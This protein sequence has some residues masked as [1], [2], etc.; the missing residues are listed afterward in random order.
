MTDELLDADDALAEALGAVVADFRKECRRELDLFMAESR[1][2]VAELKGEIAVLEA[3]LRERAN[4]ELAAIPA[5]LALVKD[6]APGRDGKSVEIADVEQMVGDAVQ[7][8]VAELPPAPAGKDANMAV[9]REIIEAEVAQAVAA[10]PAPKD[11]VGLKGGFIDHE[12]ALV[13]TLS[14]GSVSLPGRVKGLDGRT[15]TAEDI[16]PIVLEEVKAAVA[17]LPEPEPGPPPDPDDIAEM[18]R[19]EID[20]RIADM[21]PPKDGIDGRDGVDGQDGKSV[22][23]IEIERMVDDAIKKLPVP[24]DGKD[25]RSIDQAEVEQMVGAA[26]AGAIDLL[27][28]AQNGANGCDGKD[29]RD[30]TDGKDAD[31]ALMKALVIQHVDERMA[32]IPRPQD[33]RDGKDADWEAIERRIDWSVKAAVSELPRPRD[34]VD[35]KDGADGK[36]VAPIEIEQMVAKAIEVLP[37]PRDGVDGKSLSADDVAPLIQGEIER[38]VKAI[39]APKDG[40]DGIDGKDGSGIEDAF[41]G[42]DGE[43]ILVFDKGRTK[44]LGAG[45]AKDINADAIAELIA[46]S[47]EDWHQGTWE[48]GRRY[49]AAK[50]T[51]YG[52]SIFLS[53]VETDEQPTKSDDWVLILKRGRDGKDAETPRLPRPSLSL[54]PKNEDV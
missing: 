19:R 21:P 18:V 35:G 36:S 47:F 40:R 27:P 6:G 48:P 29:G 39:P 38:Q 44:N 3:Q 16:R 25:G 7:K 45:F 8:A 13:L 54:P 49:K 52:G 5:A 17:A 37:K 26:V 14:D 32:A 34:G 12:G 20:R 9:V 22:D 2:T 15:P 43:L 33:G 46:K 4:A 51:T 10:I 24:K 11:G 31:P 23:P 28:P 50:L 30:G 1:A 42:R 53:R 41:I